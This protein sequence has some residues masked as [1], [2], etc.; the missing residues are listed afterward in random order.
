MAA[1]E[2]DEWDRL[3]LEVALANLA[4]DKRAEFQR[5]RD[6]GQRRHAADLALQLK[7]V[8]TLK[9]KLSKLK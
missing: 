9:E 1:L 5:V 7:D 2:L 6:A 3:T 8:E 4:H